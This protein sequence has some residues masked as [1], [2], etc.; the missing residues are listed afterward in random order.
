MAKKATRRQ[1]GVKNTGTTIT[2]HGIF[3]GPKVKEKPKSFAER[4]TE[5]FHNAH[6]D[7]STQEL[8][9]VAAHVSSKV[10]ETTALIAKLSEQLSH[11][12]GDLKFYERQHNVLST[13][14][15]RRR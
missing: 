9:R 1:R 11:A 14:V 13:I 10:S 8:Q 3:D 15:E 5:E 7:L 4:Q 12:R 2:L 6:K